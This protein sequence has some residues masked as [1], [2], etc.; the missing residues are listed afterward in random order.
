MN[1][2]PMKH[3]AVSIKFLAANDLVF[4]MSDAGTGK[5][6]VEIVDFANRRKKK[7]KCALVLATKSLLDD[8]KVHPRETYADV[9]DRLARHAALRVVATVALTLVNKFIKIGHRLF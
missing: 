2:K 3:Q 6:L 9:I 7:G 5:T 8:L 4:D 1:Y